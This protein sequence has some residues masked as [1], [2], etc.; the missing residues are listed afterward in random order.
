MITRLLGTRKGP[1]RQREAE[2]WL[3]VIDACLEEPAVKPAGKEAWKG[4]LTVPT[5]DRGAAPPDT[6]RATQRSEAACAAPQKSHP[7]LPGAPWWAGEA[8]GAA[9]G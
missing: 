8:S 3:D 1:G 6:A 7:P 2:G 9:F 5:V 4:A